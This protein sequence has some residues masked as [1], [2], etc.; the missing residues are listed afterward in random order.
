MYKV[1]IRKEIKKLDE[2]LEFDSEIIENIN[3]LEI[4]ETEDTLEIMKYYEKKEQENR[5]IKEYE[6]DDEEEEQQEQQQ[7]GVIDKLETLFDNI[8]LDKKSFEVL[9]ISNIMDKW[10]NLKKEII[11]N[12]H[13]T[14][15]IA[16]LM[17]LS[18]YYGNKNILS[19]LIKN[20][21]FLPFL[22]FFLKY[23]NKEKN[24]ETLK[25]S[26]V[27][28]MDKIDFILNL[29][30]GKEENEHILSSK[31]CSQF[32]K[33]GYRTEL[34]RKLEIPASKNFPLD[35]ELTGKY[36]YS[37]KLDNMTIEIRMISTGIMEYTK[38]IE[39]TKEEK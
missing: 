16:L 27:L 12:K 17:H 28:S 37:D 32:D 14:E 20:Y 21:S 6:D 5:E 24:E 29:E 10:K 2:A 18:K 34:K 7:I 9:N 35:I 23:K 3:I 31:I 4:K 36:I 22:I 30:V 8:E 15:T 38:T 39:I 19:N 1:K 26:D 33:T 25:I 13:D 11:L